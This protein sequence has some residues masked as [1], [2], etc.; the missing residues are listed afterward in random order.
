[1]MNHGFR[2]EPVCI[3]D[4]LLKTDPDTREQPETFEIRSRREIGL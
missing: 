4:I 2:A 1:M 3:K